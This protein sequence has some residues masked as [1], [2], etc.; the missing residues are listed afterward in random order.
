M[1]AMIEDWG[2][3]YGETL[4]IMYGTDEDVTIGLHCKKPSC[5]A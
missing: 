5:F 1:T 4:P 2:T 3:Y